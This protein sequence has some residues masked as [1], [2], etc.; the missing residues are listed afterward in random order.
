MNEHEKASWTKGQAR[1]ERIGNWINDT[2]G[3]CPALAWLVS[4]IVITWFL[5]LAVG[6][7]LLWVI[8]RFRWPITIILSIL[9]L[10][11]LMGCSTMESS[12]AGQPTIGQT[13]NVAYDAW[14]R[15]Q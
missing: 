4:M 8:M 3:W 12:A 2:L 7:C 5:M 11:Q 9:I 10:I 1:G 14:C 15:I 6:L 13:V